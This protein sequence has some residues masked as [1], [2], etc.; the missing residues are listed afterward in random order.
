M[1]LPVLLQTSGQQNGNKRTTARNPINP[2][3]AVFRPLDKRKVHRNY[4]IE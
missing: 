3:F 4:E 1:A 2:P